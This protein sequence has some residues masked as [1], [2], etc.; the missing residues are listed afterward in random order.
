MLRMFSVAVVGVVA[1]TGVH[2]HH[3]FAHFEEG[4]SELE[5]TL[6]DLRWRNPHIYFFLETVE[7]NGETKVWEM[8]TGTIYMIGR[9]GV[10]R[11]M[12]NVGDTQR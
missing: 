3:S 10:T 5:G 7:E 12:F 8:E 1:A 4:W 2:A 11:D 6:V 9:A